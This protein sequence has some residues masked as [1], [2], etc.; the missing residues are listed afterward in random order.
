MRCGGV[1]RS[2][3]CPSVTVV[4]NPATANA[5]R[6]RAI[7]R[8]MKMTLMVRSARERLA[9][10]THAK[11]RRLEFT[12]LAINLRTS[13]G[14]RKARYKKPARSITPL[15][16]RWIRRKKNFRSLVLTSLHRHRWE[17]EEQEGHHQGG[18]AG[19]SKNFD[20]FSGSKK[21]PETNPKQ[22]DARANRLGDIGKQIS[23]EGWP[24]A[25]YN[26]P[27]NC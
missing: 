27:K 11:P 12:Q 19:Y 16:S 23:P 3:Y 8:A 20:H 14:H 13:S 17:N 5:A 25:K 24:V 2:S 9:T 22:S 7:G 18:D 10:K 15:V 6:S 1:S 4:T 21:L 26:Q